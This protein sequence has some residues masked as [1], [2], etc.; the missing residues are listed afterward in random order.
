ME[1]Y[2]E[3]TLLHNL[4]IL[5]FSLKLA[6]IMTHKC[7]SNRKTVLICLSISTLSSFLFIEHSSWV[8]WVME[9]LIFILAF[10]YYLSTYLVF[11]ASRFLF[12]VL[13]MNLFFGTIYNHQYFVFEIKSVFLADMI[14][15]LIYKMMTHKAKYALCEHDFV[16]FFRLFH[17]TYKGYLDSGNLAC[18]QTIPIIFVKDNLYEKFKTEPIY[19]DIDS[20]AQCEMLKGFPGEIIINRKKIKVICCRLSAQFPYD[21]LLNMKGLL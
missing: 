7:F 20:V 19:L 12:H 18:Y 6:L 17:H 13:Y 2:V 8:I 4:L 3:I 10:Y 21:A 15:L 9:F 14:L 11:I 16:V 5:A 1:S